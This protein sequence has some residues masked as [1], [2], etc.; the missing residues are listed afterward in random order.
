MAYI[1]YVMGIWKSKTDTNIYCSIILFL[2][3]RIC[4]KYNALPSIWKRIDTISIIVSRNKAN[5]VSWQNSKSDEKLHGIS[6][7]GK[8]S[9]FYENN[10]GKNA[11]L[12]QM[13]ILLVVLVM[14]QKR[15]ASGNI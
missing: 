3:V 11:L 10:F 14:F 12:G 9:V 4:P 8:I 7:M 1:I 13:D 2:C 15:N 6:Y 5:N